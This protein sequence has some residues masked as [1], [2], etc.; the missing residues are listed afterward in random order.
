MA[1]L[2]AAARPDAHSACV[3]QPTAP[4]V[5]AVARAM[6]YIDTHLCE[7]IS[8]AQLAGAA[9]M[10]RFHFARVFREVVGASPMEYLR[11]RRIERAQV[12]LRERRHSISQ[13]A[14]DL[15]FFDQSHF[16]RSFRHATGCTPARFAAQDAMDACAALTTSRAQVR[17]GH[18]FSTSLE[19]HP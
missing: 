7:P 3:N 11:G 2:I 6:H 17:G 14:T 1:G 5:R 12:L 19:H 9:C 10:S 15:C 18:A 16:V 8:V 13:I 4:R